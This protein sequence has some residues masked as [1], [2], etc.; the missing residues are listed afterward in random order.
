MLNESYP[1]IFPLNLDSSDF[2]GGSVLK[3]LMRSYEIV[4][5]LLSYLFEKGCLSESAR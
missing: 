4:N 1:L 2:G 3:S 5:D